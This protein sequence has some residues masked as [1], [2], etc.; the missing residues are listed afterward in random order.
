MGEGSEAETK[1]HI[2]GTGERRSGWCTGRLE[3]TRKRVQAAF[4]PRVHGVRRPRNGPQVYH[5]LED[6]L[7]LP[8]QFSSLSSQ[9]NICT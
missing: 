1:K 3:K 6:Q 8:S 2:R 9:E 4:T 5:I 7:P